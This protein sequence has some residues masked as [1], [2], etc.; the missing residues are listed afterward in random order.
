MSRRAREGVGPAGFTVDD[1]VNHMSLF[2]P[3]I[4]TDLTLRSSL[5]T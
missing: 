3:S 1:V 4:G 5:R 2:H